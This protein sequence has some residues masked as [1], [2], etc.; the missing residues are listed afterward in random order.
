MDQSLQKELKKLKTK[1]ELEMVKNVDCFLDDYGSYSNNL[2][3]LKLNLYELAIFC[4]PK[5]FKKVML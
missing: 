5:S 4:Y 1:F 2:V 3:I